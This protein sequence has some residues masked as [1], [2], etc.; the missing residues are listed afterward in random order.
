MK[1]SGYNDGETEEIKD[2]ARELKKYPSRFITC[3]CTGIPAYEIM[4]PILKDKLEYVHSGEEI[5]F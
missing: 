3:H 1:K 2:I 5:K 4:K